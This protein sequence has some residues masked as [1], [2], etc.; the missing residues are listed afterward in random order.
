M[1]T[2]EIKNRLGRGIK[3]TNDRIVRIRLDPGQDYGDKNDPEVE[4]ENLA[5]R[6]ENPGNQ[7]VP[8]NHVFTSSAAAQFA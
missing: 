6:V 2:H 4:I 3:K 7:V 1:F 8:E 5:G